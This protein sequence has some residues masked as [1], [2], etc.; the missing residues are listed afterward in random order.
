VDALLVAQPVALLLG[1]D[2]LGDQVVGG[3]VVDV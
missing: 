1:G 2:Q 3:V